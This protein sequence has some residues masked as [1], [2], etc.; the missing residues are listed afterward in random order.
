M[1]RKDVVQNQCMFVP[2]SAR[3]NC[4]YCARLAGSNGEHC[5][6]CYHVFC[7]MCSGKAI[8]LPEGLG[9]G[10]EPQPVCVSCTLLVGSFSPTFLFG[11]AAGTGAQILEPGAFLGLEKRKRQPSALFRLFVAPCT[12]HV[13]ED[14]L[15]DYDPF[16]HT[17]VTLV[18][19]RPLNKQTAIDIGGRVDIPLAR[20]TTMTIAQRYRCLISFTVERERDSKKEPLTVT[21]ALSVGECDSEGCFMP[22]PKLTQSFAGTLSKILEHF[23]N[24]K[25]CPH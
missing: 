14:I 1:P 23:R 12:R 22:D 4:Y 15:P 17:E 18:A 25:M 13:D 2:K 11:A 8:P 7:P 21:L 20:V 24:H 9:F 19:W 6:L 16:P 10:Q 3:A 5:R